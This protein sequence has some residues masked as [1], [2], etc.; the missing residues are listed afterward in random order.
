MARHV[1][2]SAH[3]LERRSRVSGICLR[4]GTHEALQFGC[5]AVKE[6][7]IGEGNRTSLHYCMLSEAVSRVTISQLVYAIVAVP[8]R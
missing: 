5:I 8:G 2:W 4:S 3:W 6:R 1:K 7:V